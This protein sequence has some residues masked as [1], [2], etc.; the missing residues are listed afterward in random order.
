VTEEPDIHPD[1]DAIGAQ[2]RA[3]TATVEAPASLRA[4]VEAERSRAAAPRDRGRAIGRAGARGRFLP[5]LAGA[6]AALAVALVLIVGGGGGPSGPSVADAAQLALAQPTDGPPA[7]QETFVDASESGIQFPNY[8]WKWKTLKVAGKRTDALKGHHTTTVVYRGPRGSVGYTIVGGKALP[9]PKDAKQ[10][11]SAGLDLRIYKQ[12]GATVV[13]WR[14]LGHT[15][16]LAS[17]SLPASQL[18]RMATWI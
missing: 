2:I 15:C 13:T 3:L 11:R 18:V 14:E 9:W 12:D 4:R 6:G 1:S 16:V 10:V 7:V 8:H 5:A 17:R